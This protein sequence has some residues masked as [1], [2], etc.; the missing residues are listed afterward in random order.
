VAR[1]RVT[2]AYL[3]LKSNEPYRYA[4][5]KRVHQK[6]TGLRS[7]AT[8]KIKRGKPGSAPKDLP[9]ACARHGLPPVRRFEE[10]PA[11]E[12]RMLH[13]RGLEPAVRELHGQPAAPQ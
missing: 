2:I 10:L 9:A 5:C 13:E 4:V 8:G 11:G 3:M 12:R 6:F 7:A 1:K